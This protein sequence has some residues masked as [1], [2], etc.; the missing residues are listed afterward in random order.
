MA[1]SIKTLYSHVVLENKIRELTPLS[2]SKFTEVGLSIAE[3]IE[4]NEWVKI[5]DEISELPKS[6]D[7]PVPN[8]MQLRLDDQS[9]K[10]FNSLWAK[11]RRILKENHRLSTLR[12]QVFTLLVWQ[13]YYDYLKKES[14]NVGKEENTPALHEMTAPEM[15]KT[16]A[17]IVLLNREQDRSTIINIKELLVEWKNNQK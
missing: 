6:G 17:E 5:F 7:L 8:S 3:N 2:R 9:T 12:K 1:E 16:L 4:D 13:G 11:V 10:T 14:M 15:F